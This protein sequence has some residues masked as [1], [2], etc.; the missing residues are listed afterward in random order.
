MTIIEHGAEKSQQLVKWLVK[1]KVTW[2]RKSKIDEMIWK[3]WGNRWGKA[4]WLEFFFKKIWKTKS[5]IVE[6]VHLTSL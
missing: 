5:H 3:E 6:V 4:V 1:E 2:S